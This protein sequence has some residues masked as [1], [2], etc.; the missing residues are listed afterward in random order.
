MEE[1][2]SIHRKFEVCGR[3]VFE[4]KRRFLVCKDAKIVEVHF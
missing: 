3:K 2:F 1:S 4:F